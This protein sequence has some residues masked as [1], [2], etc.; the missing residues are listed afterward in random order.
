[1][2]TN[3][4]HPPA[5][6]ARLPWKVTV[7]GPCASGKSTLEARL[8]SAGVAVRTVAQ[9]HSHVP[10]LWQISRPDVLVYLDVDLA[11]L[12]QRRRQPWTQEMLD[13]Q[14]RRLAHAQAHAHL[15]LPSNELPPDEVAARVLHYLQTF[16]PAARTLPPDPDLLRAFRGGD[17]DPE[18]T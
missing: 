6:P 1:M 18:A 13:E 5:R 4:S 10:Y 9:E 2:T 15:V 7:V 16:D 11:T 14:H 17:L 12:R 8:T 3:G